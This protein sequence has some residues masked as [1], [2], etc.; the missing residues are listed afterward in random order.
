MKFIVTEDYDKMSKISAEYITNQILKEPHSVLGLAT[1]STPIGMYKYLIEAYKNGLDFSN[2]IT[3][4]LDEYCG[5]SSGHPQSYRYFM[6]TNLFNHVNINKNN[7]HMP[8]G[9]CK[10]ME[11]ECQ[12]YDAAISKAGGI[13]LQ[14]LGIGRNGHIG[15]NEPQDELEVKTH[16]AELHEDTIKANSRFFNSMDEVPK[17]AITMGLGT[18]M[19][20]KKIV[21]LAFGADKAPVIAKIS[22]PYVDTEIPASV[23]HL[24]N[25]VV[26]IVDKEAAALVSSKNLSFAAV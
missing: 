22:E 1:G 5:L 14:I 12:K 15:F 7:I 11:N 20:A 26:V 24:H 3:F 21:L 6:D 13:N 9:L 23:L 10:D 8:D 25:D 16:V 19:K 18:I 17:M 2:V 4:N